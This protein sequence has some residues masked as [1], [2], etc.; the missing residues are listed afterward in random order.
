MEEKV[1]IRPHRLTIEN[2]GSGMM[3]GIREVVSFDENQVVL[4]TDMGLLT[5]KGKGLHV[6]RLT[7]EKGEVDLNGNIESLTYSSNEALRRSGESMISR[8]FK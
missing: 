4:D 2:R 6:S 3:T 1:N 5:L 8:L 7:L